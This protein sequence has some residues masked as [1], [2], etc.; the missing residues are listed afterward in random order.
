MS[1]SGS[2]APSS[3]DLS[4]VPARVAEAFSRMAGFCRE[5]LRSEPSPEA[6]EDGERRARESVNAFA[7]EVLGAVIEKRDDGASRIERNGQKWFRLAATP[8][9][10]MTSLGPVSYRRARYRNGASRTSLVPVDETLGLVNDYLTRP[11]AQLGLMMMGHCTA[12]EAE[13]FFEKIGGMTPSVS[14][15]QRLT[16]RMHERLGSL[17]PEALD[18]IRS[19]EDIPHEAV[20]ASVSLDGVMVALCAGEDGHAEASWRE[21]ACGTISF[22]DAEGTRLKTLYL[23]RMPESRKVTLKAQLASEVA[24]IRDV[25][26]EIGIVAIADGAA[27]NWTFLGSLSPETEVIDFWHACEHL[28]EASDHAVAAHWFEKH[29]EILRHDPRGVAKVIRA[30]CYLRDTAKSDRAVIERELAFFRKHRHR[31]RYHA[32][33][34]E[35]IAIGSGVVEAANKTLVTQRMKRSG[36]RWRDRRRSGRSDLPSSDQIRP[37]RPGM[38]GPDE[39][40]A[41]T[42]Q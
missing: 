36:M 8:K 2:P 40:N 11:A 29:R 22:H 26:T 23:G 39:R 9:T 38:G 41:Y 4:G 32:L 37:L 19:A 30:L 34:E 21:A 7:C 25:R 35:S 18:G 20:S 10:I 24:H 12:R 42:R 17:G 31:M 33:K 5:Q 6:F 16:L 15:L 13:E 1:V 3:I 28:R 14:T 27:D